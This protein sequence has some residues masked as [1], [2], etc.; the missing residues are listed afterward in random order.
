MRQTPV[1]NPSPSSIGRTVFLNGEFLAA[2]DARVSIADQGVLFGFGF[3]ESFRTSGG[4]VHLWPLHRRRLEQACD[5]A[6][7]ELP[8]WFLAKDE[9][10]LNAAVNSLLCAA[11]A[12]DAAFRYTVTGG[13]A[14]GR[15]S[16]FL[17]MRPLP[18]AV[19]GEGICLRVLN[20]PRDNG[21]WLPRPKSLN[22]VNA[23]V[24]ARE[25]ALRTADASDEGLF[26]SRD[27]E[28]IVETARQNVVWLSDGE[29]RYPDPSI[30]ALSG[31]CL[32]WLLGLGSAARPRRAHLDELLGAE[33]IVVVNSVRGITP[34][35]QL[36][37]KRDEILID[38]LASRIHPLIV[39]LRRQWSEALDA[40]A[41]GAQV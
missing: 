23:L 5:V 34:V 25:L 10:R 24:G 19:E 9:Q 39:S 38:Q 15:P 14:G 2:T 18:A 36:R 1:A 29:I 33:A 16:E 6:R 22:Y 17:T 20:L 30:G 21:E 13:P 41:S 28:Y 11:G 12:A 40:T 26:L 37:G 3:F 31:T 4:R 32:T 7:L 27:D 35:R 8:D